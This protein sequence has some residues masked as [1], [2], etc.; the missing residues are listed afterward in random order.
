MNLPTSNWPKSYV[1]K[2][3]QTKHYNEIILP[4]QMRD[5]KNWSFHADWEICYIQF[6]TDTTNLKSYP[7]LQMPYDNSL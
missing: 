6:V 2:G 3:D 4:S 5:G 7:Y 1:Q